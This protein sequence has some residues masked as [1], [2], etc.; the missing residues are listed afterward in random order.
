VVAEHAGGGRGRAHAAD[1]GVRFGVR[2][3]VRIRDLDRFPSNGG[4]SVAASPPFPAFH[5]LSKCAKIVSVAI[6]LA[7]SPAAA[8]AH[9]VGD[10]EQRAALTQ[11]VL[12]HLRL[13]R[14]IL[15]RKIRDE[16]AVLVVLAGPADVGLAEH[17]HA[18]GL[19]GAVRTW[20]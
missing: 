13:K 8:A 7:S 20:R 15:A 11:I 1:F 2:V 14:R 10:D 16:E 9:A 3:D 19:G 6:W 18:N 4:R 5:A 12:A 17:L